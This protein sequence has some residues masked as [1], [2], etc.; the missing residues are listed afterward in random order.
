VRLHRAGCDAVQ[1]VA[2]FVFVTV[3]PQ[4]KG[5]NA[6]F[7]PCI[8]IVGHIVMF[9]GAVTVMAVG[10]LVEMVKK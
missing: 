3:F 8:L 9:T 1:A 10:R 2:G 5:T 4:Q 6:M 7:F